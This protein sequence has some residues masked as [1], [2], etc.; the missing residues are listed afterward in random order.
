[1]NLTSN[2]TKATICKNV[3]Q[4]LPFIARIDLGCCFILWPFFGT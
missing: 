4:D 3:I 2:K 1:M